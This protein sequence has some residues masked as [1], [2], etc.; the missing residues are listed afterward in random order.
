MANIGKTIRNLRTANK[1]TQDDLAEKLFVSR[2]TISNYETGKSN[3][4]ID[5][6][7]KIADVF[8]SDV[9]TIIYGL[10]KSYEYKKSV[11]K[12]ILS[13][14]FTLSLG[15]ISFILLRKVSQIFVYSTGI[16][17]WAQSLF[18]PCFYLMLG[19][20]VTQF[21]ILLFK[22]KPLSLRYSTQIHHLTLG[23][24]I[25]YF[26]MI[27]PYVIINAIQFIQEIQLLTMFHA[28]EITEFTISH[29]YSFFPAWD[30]VAW[31]IMYGLM[32]WKL[33][34]LFVIPGAAL[35]AVK[36]TF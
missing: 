7:I 20:S 12:L 31:K 14:I 30:F 18:I 25:T 34:I 21:F 1:M 13:C 33:N 15:I 36:T 22:A 6:L 4:D 28:G 26:I 23:L 29:S 2:Q 32:V 11:L 16:S 24:L 3:P 8:N 9:N 19:K 35:Q 10:P 5:M 17:F 27:C